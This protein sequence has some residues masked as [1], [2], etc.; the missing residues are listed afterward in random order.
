MEHYPFA[1]QSAS[2]IYVEI[3]T[4]IQQSFINNKPPAPATV[5][6]MKAFVEELEK[7]L[8]QYINEYYDPQY[9]PDNKPNFY[10]YMIDKQNY[11]LAVHTF[12]P[13]SFA[14]FVGL[15]YHKVEI[16]NIKNRSFNIMTLQE[17]LDNQDF[18]KEMNKP[19]SNIG[20]FNQREQKH[21]NA[22]K[23]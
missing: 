15:N 18:Q 4:P 7:G 2:P 16:S 9:A 23:D 22:S 19:I 6:P 11:H 1:N 8:N 10:I 5:K 21:L 13:F 20:F 14:R 3:A 12:S 17:L